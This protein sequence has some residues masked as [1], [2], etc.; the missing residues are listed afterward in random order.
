MP[1]TPSP[2]SNASYFQE[3]FEKKNFDLDSGLTFFVCLAGYARFFIWPRGLHAC[4][5]V[6][7]RLML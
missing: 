7:I 2:F 4:G 6:V 5:T 3:A 1:M